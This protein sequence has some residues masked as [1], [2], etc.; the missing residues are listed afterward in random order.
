MLPASTISTIIEDFQN[1][2]DLSHGLK[3]LSEKLKALEIS[4]AIVGNIIEEMRRDDLLRFYNRELLNTDQKT[5]TVFKSHFD[6][7]EPV[8]LFL[9]NDENVLPSI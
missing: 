7:V 5:K 6:Y 3:I 9:G 4:E 2:H 8:P 1:A